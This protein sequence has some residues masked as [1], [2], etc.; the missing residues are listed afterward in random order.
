MSR[1]ILITY[2]NEMNKMGKKIMDFKSIVCVFNFIPEH[3]S[4]SVDV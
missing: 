1:K 3:V 4:I 2:K